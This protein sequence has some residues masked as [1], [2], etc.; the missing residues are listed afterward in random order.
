V[1]CP[2]VCPI[3]LTRSNLVKTTARNTIH[4]RL[5][6]QLTPN[7]VRS[8]PWNTTDSVMQ[9]LFRV[10]MLWALYVRN[11][12]LYVWSLYDWSEITIYWEDTGVEYRQLSWT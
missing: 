11:A 12:N 1:A 6:D 5:H 9:V 10:D 7:S 8:G 3:V 2:N 4:S